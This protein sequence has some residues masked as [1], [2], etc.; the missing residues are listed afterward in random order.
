MSKRGKTHRVPIEQQ[1]LGETDGEFLT[2]L[3]GL[4]GEGLGQNE[5][6]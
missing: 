6:L 3:T 4:F 1:T 2:G 5:D